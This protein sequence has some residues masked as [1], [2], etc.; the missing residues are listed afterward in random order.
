MYSYFQVQLL[1]WKTCISK[2]CQE[3]FVQYLP[4][5]IIKYINIDIQY[6]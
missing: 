2:Y 3:S 1:Q 4:V 6:I 5:Y